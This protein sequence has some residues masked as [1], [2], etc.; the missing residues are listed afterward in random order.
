MF[1]YSPALAWGIPLI[2]RG[3]AATKDTVKTALPGAGVVAQSS[4][5]SR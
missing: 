3:S 5:Q 4:P 2:E 1:A